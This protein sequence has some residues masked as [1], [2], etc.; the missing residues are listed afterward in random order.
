M[1]AP[2]VVVVGHGPSLL[3]RRLG[4]QID[5]FDVVI[6]QKRCQDSLKYPDIYGTKKDVVCG[7]WTIAPELP[8]VGAGEVWAFLDSRHANVSDAALREAQER[9]PCRIDRALCDYWNRYY[10]ARRKPYTRP[11]GTQEFDPLGHPHLS[12]GFHTLLYACEFLKPSIVTLAGFDNIESGSFTW[13]ITRGPEWS[14]Y[15]DHRWDIE[16][17]LLVD[18][19]DEFNV[20]IAFL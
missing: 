14:M 8:N 19:C 15:P 16:H 4:E 10:R 6:R 17:E 9:I 18:V 5:S 7:S 13:S 1:A 3:S 20:E 11:R 2:S 12:A